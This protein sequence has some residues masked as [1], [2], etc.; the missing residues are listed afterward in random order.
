MLLGILLL[1]GLMQQR[2]TDIGTKIGN[3]TV[4]AVQETLSEKA[5]TAPDFQDG[6][7]AALRKGIKDEVRPSLPAM[8]SGRAA[9]MPNLFRLGCNCLAMGA[10]AS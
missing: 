8:R 10:F 9:P 4:E 5:G 2:Q 7:G 6:L 1:S 3:T